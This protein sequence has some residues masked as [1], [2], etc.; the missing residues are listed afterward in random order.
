EERTGATYYPEQ[1]VYSSTPSQ[2]P[3]EVTGQLAASVGAAEVEELAQIVGVGVARPSGQSQRALGKLN[4]GS[5][6]GMQA[7]RYFMERTFN[8]GAVQVAMLQ[9]VKSTP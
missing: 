5:A 2:F 8:D 3:Q 9:A 1:N 4:Y 7:G 6:D